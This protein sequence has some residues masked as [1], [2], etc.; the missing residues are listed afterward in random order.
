MLND[1]DVH[2]VPD[3]ASTCS[4]AETITASLPQNPTPFEYLRLYFSDEIV[5]AIVVETNRYADQYITRNVIPPHSSVRNWVP[6]SRDEMLS[7]L[8]LCLLMGLVYKPRLSMYWSGDEIYR[9]PVFG[10]VMARDRFLLILRFLHCNDNDA[11]DVRNPYRD[12]LHKIRPVISML[13]SNCASVCQPGRDLCVDESLVLYKGRLAFKQFIR[14]K[15]ARFGIK[16]FELCTSN[17]ILL[18][19]IVYH[20]KT[21]AELLKITGHDFLFSEQIPLTLMEK[22][23]DKGHRLFVDNYYTSTVLAQYLLD[24]GTKLVGTVRPTRRNFPPELANVQL[25]KGEMKYAAS[26]T[27]ILAVKYRAT[28]DKSNNKPKVVH[29]LTTDHKNE[30]SPTGKKDRDGTT[31]V[32]PKC[33]LDYN[34]HMGGVDLVDLVDQQ[35]E[36]VLAIRKTYKWYKKVLFRLFLQSA[37][38]AHKLHQ[39]AAE[40]RPKQDFL[41]FLHDCVTVMIGKSP[42]LSATACAGFDSVARLTGREHFPSKRE[43]EGEGHKRSSKKKKC[44]VCTARGLRSPKGGQVETTWVC[45]ACPSI[46]GLCVEKGCFREYHTKLDYSK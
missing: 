45:E 6:T 46:P 21:R 38:S 11:T 1:T 32:K 44:R 20:R 28:T 31:I 25:N 8:G 22:Y 30:S 5:D 2:N 17:G 27:G 14:S 29:V 41:K 40:V 33:V 3:V 34:R 18:D 39:S 9:T 4:E 42:R 23:L 43:Y 12:R 26:H 35:L 37:L 16:M 19:F 10:Q 24:R 7:F 15:R 13:R 36:S